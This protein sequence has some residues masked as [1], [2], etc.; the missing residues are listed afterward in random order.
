M[1]NAWHSDCGLHSGATLIQCRMSGAAER[2]LKWEGRGSGRE[3]VSR[4]LEGAGGILP[5]KM[6]EI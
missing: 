1:L 4:K 6:C 3:C 2:V 5:R